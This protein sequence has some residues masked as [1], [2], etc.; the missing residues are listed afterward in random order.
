MRLIKQKGKWKLQWQKSHMLLLLFISLFLFSTLFINQQVES[1]FLTGAV[2]TDSLDNDSCASILLISIIT[3]SLLLGL[4]FYAVN[5]K[6]LVLKK[7]NKFRNKNH[8]SKT[9]T[10]AIFVA[11]LLMGMFLFVLDGGITGMNVVMF[12]GE[13]NYTNQTHFDDG[14]YTN[15]IFNT[16]T[17]A[18]ELDRT[19]TNGTFVSEVFNSS[20]LTNWD[21]I[22]WTPGH[23]Y[24]EALPCADEDEEATTIGGINMSN[25]HH[26]YYLDTVGTSVGQ[27]DTNRICAGENNINPY[28]GS[29]VI[30]CTA[31]GL[32]GGACEF[33][34]TSATNDWFRMG[35]PD[36]DGGDFSVS[37]WMNANEQNTSDLTILWYEGSAWNRDQFLIELKNTTKKVS[38]WLHDGADGGG[39]C[40]TSGDFNY[41]QWQHIVFIKNSSNCITYVNGIKNNTVSL[42]GT[43]NQASYYSNRQ[44]MWMGAGGQWPVADTSSIPNATIDEL[45]IWK[46]RQLTDTEIQNIY[47]RGAGKVNISVQSCDDASCSGES[48]TETVTNSAN[49]DLSVTDDWYFQYQINMEILNETMT[50]QLFNVSLGYTALNTPANHSTPILNGSNIYNNSYA[51][52][53]VYNQSTNDADGDSVKNI[54]DWRKDGN[55]IA[56][57][58]MPFEAGSLSGDADGVANAAKDYSQYSNN[59]TAYN[60]TYNS[61]GG[62]DGK[63]AYMFDGASDYIDLNKKAIPIGAKTISFWVKTSVSTDG[64]LIDDCG[65]ASSL[66][67]TVITMDWTGTGTVKAYSNKGSAGDGRW[68]V[69]G[70][71][72]VSD[73]KWHHIVLTWDG[74]TDSDTVKLYVDNIVEAN[75]TAD[76]TEINPASFNTVVG[77]SGYDLSSPFNGTIDEVIIYNHSLSA[78]QIQ[79]LYNNRTDLIVSQ[80][81]D[82]GEI[83]QACITPN[84]GY[85]DGLENCSNTFLVRNQPPILSNLQFTSSSGGNTT[86]DNISITY[87]ILDPENDTVKNITNWYVNGTSIMVLNMPF[88]RLNETSNDNAKDYSPYSNNGT[89]NGSTFNASGGYDGA[90]AYMFD[91]VDDSVIVPDDDSLDFGTSTDFTLSAWIKRNSYGADNDVIMEKRGILGAQ[92]GLLIFLAADNKVYAQTYSGDDRISSTNTFGDNDWHHVVF[93]SDRSLNQTIYVDGVQEATGLSNQTNITTDLPLDIGATINIDPANYFNGTIDDLQIYNRS[94]S[95]TQILALYNNQTN[96]IVS[97]ELTA[98]DN[99]SACAIGND[100]AEDGAELCS[101]N[102]TINVPNELTLNSGNFSITSGSIKQN[103]TVEVN[104]TIFNTGSTNVASANISFYIDDTYNTS[105]DISINQSSSQLVQFNWTAVSGNHTL[106]VRS[107]P[108]NV[109]IEINENDN[110]QEQNVSINYVAVL[111]Y[112][113]PTGELARGSD[114]AFEDVLGEVSNT[115][116][117]SARVYNL[118]NTSHGLSANCSFY[119]N[120]SLLDTVET[121]SS[122]HCNYTLTK[123]SYDYGSYNITTNF[124]I[125]QS[126]AVKHTSEIENTTNITLFVIN[127]QITVTNQYSGTSYMVGE[128]AVIS[129]NVTRDDALYTPDNI[130]V[131]V[132]GSAGPP[133]FPG[134]LYTDGTGLYRFASLI[135]QSPSGG[136]IRW[137]VRINDTSLNT[138]GTAQDEDVTVNTADSTFNLTLTDASGN[139][140]NATITIRDSSGYTLSQQSV[141]T[142]SLLNNSVRKN[143]NHTIEIVTTNNETIV[144]S[145]IYLNGTTNLLSLQIIRIPSES[146]PSTVHNLTRIVAFESFPFTLGNAT[147]TLPK[148]VRNISSILKCSSWNSTSSNCTGSWTNYSTTITENSTHFWFTVTEFSGYAG[149]E[150]FTSALSVSDDTDSETKYAD[151]Q[152]TFTANYTNSSSNA[153]LTGAVCNITY[154]LAPVGPST[155]TYNASSLVYYYNRTFSAAGSSDYSV[156]CTKSGF[157]SLTATDSVVISTVPSSS[158]SSSSS[159]SGGA[160]GHSLIEDD[161]ETVEDLSD[162]DTPDLLIDLSDDELDDLMDEAA[163]ALEI[164]ELVIN[165]AHDLNLDVSSAESKLGSAQNSYFAKDYQ[166]ALSLAEQAKELAEEVVLGSGTTPVSYSTGRAFFHKI[167]VNITDYSYYWIGGIVVLITLIAIIYMVRVR[168]RK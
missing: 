3:F 48:W 86:L 115:E 146:V 116:T 142:T 99:W 149:G 83:W 97:S 131:N 168:K 11:V 130:T 66:D 61:T 45:S 89:I 87:G 38:M 35:D 135:T 81:T 165:Q 20:Y 34:G 24:G 12:Y 158:S 136:K 103:D 78:E 79:A 98:S 84:D 150:S 167:G 31:D 26:L 67:G 109:L 134:T 15:T 5:K 56:V 65:R 117:L 118:Y 64:I 143:K 144:L 110:D 36:L 59:G 124:T 93:T 43:W 114:L 33:K 62:Y 73:N 9:F 21:N 25:T 52:L 94:L 76:S 39:S 70:T 49:S 156:T 102:M 4:Y 112:S 154:D 148:N 157:D 101:V 80:E 166:R 13:F 63:G 147:L 108:N 55:S 119:L 123:T 90:G 58:N 163:N 46:S 28:D 141:N 85:E 96:M 125:I 18:L 159:S 88:E 132:Q 68:G 151:A 126:D 50:P 137:H 92:S 7:L 44:G 19:V 155:M 53:T 71:T 57:L 104:A 160:V 82:L 42:S 69:E 139:V 10:S 27:N 60:V 6:G 17:N 120:D 153:V 95:A 121:N 74:T 138:I 164:A 105:N 14:T 152:I 113:S 111:N 127:S 54:I 22:S 41:G 107:D 32:F 77:A 72:N 145:N 30:D 23:P 75:G 122:G 128:M 106:K 47:L 29:S 100:G 133:A 8:L 51:N 40:T 129:F 37:F 16:S 161:E 140:L 91:G 2:I 1:N 162:S